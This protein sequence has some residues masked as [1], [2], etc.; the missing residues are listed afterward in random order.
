MSA[1]WHRPLDIE[2]MNA[3]G[4]HINTLLDIRIEEAGDDWIS[5]SMPVDQRTHQPYGILHGGASR[6]IS[7]ASSSS[8]NSSNSMFTASE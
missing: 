3:P 8:R 1:I 2:A 7:R 4:P 5:A 6:R